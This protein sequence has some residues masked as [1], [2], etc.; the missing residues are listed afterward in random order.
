[1][2]MKGYWKDEAK[3]LEAIDRDG[4]MH[5]GDLGFLD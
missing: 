1:M 2:V 4:W 5:T 3:T